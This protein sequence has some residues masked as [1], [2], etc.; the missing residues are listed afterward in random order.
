MAFPSRIDRSTLGAET[1]AVVEAGGFDKWS[2]R[3]VA[4]ALGVSPN[5][6]YRHV[7]GRDDLLVEAAAC[8]TEQLAAEL[9][10]GG[11][12]A[13]GVD[14]VV[15][16][17]QRYVAFAVHRPHAYAAIVHAKPERDDPRGLAWHQLWTQVRAEVVN[18]IEHSGDAAG[19]ALWALLHGRI[20]L[21]RGAAR[22]APADAGLADAVR[23]LLE[24][25]RQIGPVPSPLPEGLRQD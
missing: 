22:A 23:A 2:L 19:F 17:A 5:A 10:R 3:D 14:R 6:L 8:A 7:D 12:P 13:E 21:A 16:I 25:H 1:L 15:E 24:G 18:A 20:Q 11:L 4:K 9:R